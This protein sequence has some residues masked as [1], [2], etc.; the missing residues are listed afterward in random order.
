MSSPILAAMPPAPPTP[1][2]EVVRLKILSWVRDSKVTQATLAAHIG[3]DQV[4]MSRYLRGAVGADLETIRRMVQAFGHNLSA[5][6]ESPPNPNEGRLLEMYRSFSPELRAQLLEMFQAI[7]LQTRG[8]IQRG[9]R[10]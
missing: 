5:V 10:R 4:W 8:R 3:R 2:D 9:P 7:Q 1:L 6:L